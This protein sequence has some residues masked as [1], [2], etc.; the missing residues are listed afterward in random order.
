MLE[1]VGGP[2]SAPA[3][4]AALTRAIENTLTLPL[5]TDV[6]PRPRGSA[7]ELMRAADILVRRGYAPNTPGETPGGMALW[8]VAFGNGARPTGWQENVSRA[9]AHRIPYIREVAIERL[10]TDV[11]PAFLPAIRANLA[12][13]NADVQIAAC[14]LVYRTKLNAVH[15][16]VSNTLGTAKEEWAVRSCGNALY[17]IGANF[18]RLDTL[19]VRLSEPDMTDMMLDMLLDLF[20]SN[21]ST[22]CC[23]T[24][25]G[26]ALS[27]RWRAFLAARRADI[28][29]GR[30]ISLDDP[31][32]P[33]DLLPPG[34][35]LH[36]SGKPDW[37]PK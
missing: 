33:V 36:R 32:I 10:P 9:L 7:Q 28:E 15:A 31:S 1:A 2:E 27:T 30:S 24:D 18:E 8:L 11:I 23:K 29:A 25:Q 26:S 16:E 34:I 19:A 20:D 6:Y 13:T 35:T 14:D 3:L 12:S 17:A 37:P 4:S 22:G 21:G 5:E